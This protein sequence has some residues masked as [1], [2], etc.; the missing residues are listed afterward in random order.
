MNKSDWMHIKPARSR[1]PKGFDATDR[2]G[3]MGYMIAVVLVVALYVM[4]A[5]S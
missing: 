4:W 5:R 1:L 2:S 3:R